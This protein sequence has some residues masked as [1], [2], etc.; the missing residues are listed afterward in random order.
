M[1]HSGH[2]GDLV[3]DEGSQSQRG[4]SQVLT[5]T[6]K[7]KVMFPPLQFLV[8]RLRLAGTPCSLQNLLTGKV[9]GEKVEASTGWEILPDLHLPCLLSKGR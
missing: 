5:R 6:A 1:M 3:H 9:L 2:S 7:Q 4:L 8:T